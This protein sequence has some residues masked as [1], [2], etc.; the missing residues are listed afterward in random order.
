MKAVIMNL[1]GISLQANMPDAKNATQLESTILLP[2]ICIILVLV[3]IASVAIT[4][5]KHKR[6]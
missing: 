2:A 6:Y 1:L 3:V 5:Q 4:V